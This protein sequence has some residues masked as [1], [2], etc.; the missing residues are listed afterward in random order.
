MHEVANPP[1]RIGIGLLGYKV[2]VCADAY[3]RRW[4]GRPV[5]EQSLSTG[6]IKMF[7]RA[8]TLS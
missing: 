5:S 3:V 8:G 2:L 4:A 1:N 7:I 6:C